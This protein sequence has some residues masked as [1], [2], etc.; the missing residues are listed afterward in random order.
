MIFEKD[1]FL[2]L[3][4]D[5]HYIVGE[6]YEVVQ[7]TAQMDNI[8]FTTTCYNIATDFIT[9]DQR[10]GLQEPFYP[11]SLKIPFGCIFDIQE[12]P[13]EECVDIVQVTIFF[14]D[15]KTMKTSSVI[16]L[17]PKLFLRRIAQLREKLFK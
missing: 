13:I 9:L 8:P 7:C 16:S 14:T 11:I 4:V 15:P 17:Y 2:I 10:E 5:S 12:T 3:Y 1:T 6:N